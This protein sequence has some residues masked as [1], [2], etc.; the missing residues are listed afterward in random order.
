VKYIPWKESVRV[1]LIPV[2][3]DKFNDVSE[4]IKQMKRPYIIKETSSSKTIKN[5]WLGFVTSDLPIGRSMLCHLVAV[6]REI[7][8]NAESI[9]IEVPKQVQWY[10]VSDYFVSGAPI[11]KMYVNEF[12][13]S[14]AYWKGAFNLN[15]ISLK[16]YEKFL[17]F[18]TKKFRLIALGML[19]RRVILTEY[20]EN[21]E[22]LSREVVCDEQGRKIFHRIA[23]EVTLEMQRLAQAYESDFRFYWFDNCV[24]SS[25]CNEIK[26][27]YQWRKT[28]RV[29]SFKYF[30]NNFHFNLGEGRKFVLP[31]S[32]LTPVGLIDSKSN[33]VSDIPF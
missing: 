2:H 8:K 12:D 28:E 1:M 5:D 24:M 25:M 9:N 23:Y 15:L 13:L 7:L 30:K 27:D 14:H 4:Q 17:K 31:S 22:R 11:R 6:R 16:T 33:K 10:A 21:N 18:K 3:I 20:N 19:A 29:M 32:S 26:T